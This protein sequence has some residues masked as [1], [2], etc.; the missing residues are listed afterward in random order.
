MVMT[1]RQ[2]LLAQVQTK[3]SSKLPSSRLVDPSSLFDRIYTLPTQTAVELFT[4][5]IDVLPNLRIEAGVISN[6]GENPSVRAVVVTGMYLTNPAKLFTYHAL[7][8]QDGGEWY[9]SSNQYP[10]ILQGEDPG[11]LTNF[12]KN[13][14]P[15]ART[16]DLAVMDCVLDLMW[17]SRENRKRGFV[18]VKGTIN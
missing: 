2:E 12:P 18:V 11:F 8:L 1:H 4:P 14:K 7:H 15:Q 16:L 3:I 6:G 5:E 17:P 10:H 9:V 13:H